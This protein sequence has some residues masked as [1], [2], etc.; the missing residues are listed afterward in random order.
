MQ[1]SAET[2]Y[3][4][5]H[6]VVRDAAYQLQPPAARGVLHL[7]ALQ[8]LELLVPPGAAGDS[9][10]LEMAAHAAAAQSASGADLPAL[11][12]RELTWLARAASHEAGLWHNRSAIELFR[13]AAR[14]PSAVP[15]QAAEWTARAATILLSSGRQA[16]A[17]PLLDQAQALCTQIGNDLA[18]GEVMALRFTHAL[19]TGD[20]SSARAHCE[21]G[22]DLAQRVG[23]IR[24]QT[25]LFNHKAQLALAR[26]DHAAAKEAAHAALAVVAD[27]HFPAARSRAYRYLADIAW[28]LGD[29]AEAEQHMRKA[30]EVAEG[31]PSG[32]LASAVD[33]LG[34]LL[35]DRGRPEEAAAMHQRALALYVQIGDSVGVGAVNTNLAGLWTEQGR[36]DEARAKYIEALG[37]FRARGIAT[38]SAVCLGNLGQLSVRTGRLREGEA[39]LRQASGDLRRLGRSIELAVFQSLLASCRLLLGDVGVASDLL[40]EADALLEKND[41]EHWRRLYSLPGLLRVAVDH[42]QRG[43]ALEAVRAAAARVVT[44]EKQPQDVE[45]LAAEVERAAAAGAAAR[46][47]RG[48]L[49]AEMQPILRLALMQASPKLDPEGWRRLAASNEAM[50]AMA[51]GTEGMTVPPWDVVEIS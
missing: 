40:H 27:G 3:L 16:E 8:V 38:Q 31:T 22:L 30:V 17:P 23:D 45:A 7:A 44:A 46:I 34:S 14:H 26:A 33:H 11:Q 42:W 28:Q 18:L 29:L 25:T 47:H 9:W 49:I 20:V 19:M 39:C 48:H 36:H 37:A 13:R 51:A 50:A 5:R 32:P 15:A 2:A 10:A 4:F 12:R 6:A 43:G 1:L 41:A 35:Q 24:L 21:A